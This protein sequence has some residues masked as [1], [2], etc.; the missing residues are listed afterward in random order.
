MELQLRADDGEV[1]ICV[2]NE[3]NK[4]VTVVPAG[5]SVVDLKLN[6]SNLNANIR[7]IPHVI[8]DQVYKR[9]CSVDDETRSYI[10]VTA[11]MSRVHDA[12]LL[13]HQIT[14]VHF[15]LQRPRC[16][17]ALGMGLGKT[18]TAITIMLA[19]E[20]AKTLVVCPASLKTNWQCE[21][22][23]FAPNLQVLN[24]KSKKH[25]EQNIENL[26]D[27][28]VILVS[29]SLVHSVVAELSQVEFDILVGDEAHY[30]KT[31]TAQRAKSFKCL[32]QKIPRCI[33]LT[34]TPAQT[35][36]DLFFLLHIIDGKL[37]KDFHHHQTVRALAPPQE[38]KLYF[39]ERY[40]APKLVHIVGGRVTYV[41]TG[42]ERSAE[43]NALILPYVLRMLSRDHL[44]LPPLLQEKVVIGKLSPSQEKIFQKR[45]LQA[46]TLLETKGKLYADSY[47]ME[48][49]RIVMRSKIIA[50][51]AY[52]KMIVDT[53]DP[54]QKI[55]V[56]AYHRVLQ[57]K[58]AELMISQNIGY[59][60]IT[61]STPMNIR[62]SM[63]SDFENNPQTRVGVLSIAACAAGLNLQ[64][65]TTTIF[66]ELIFNS[67]ILTQAAGRNYRYGSH[68]KVLHQYLV[69]DGSTDSIVWKSLKKKQHT[70]SELLDEGGASGDRI[71]TVEYSDEF[72]DLI[73]S[74]DLASEIDVGSIESSKK[75]RKR[76]RKNKK[77]DCIGQ[78]FSWFTFQN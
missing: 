72:V 73:I 33:M 59:I 50:V 25:L 75:K 38:A 15:A 11:A 47:L 66:T 77:L 42:I 9:R 58:I 63:F 60:Q 19:F 61:G 6:I 32:A 12:T 70:E 16:L 78:Y 43:L 62:K 55:I 24:I 3:K 35:H 52:L 8:V 67:I 56:F 7:R 1:N 17:L 37:F 51:L 57:D 39:A 45:M 54:S 74:N 64:F 40:C 31:S 18:L 30:V 76:N 20:D 69:L 49:L 13:P 21:L 23:R 28:D 26:E 34:A 36:A 48:S 4:I 46:E 71:S 27:F 29:F 68:T 65:A 22:C 53:S 2:V 41:F 44:E 14:A 10:A 5:Q